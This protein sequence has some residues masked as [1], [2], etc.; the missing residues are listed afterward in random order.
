MMTIKSKIPNKVEL[1]FQRTIAD[2]EDKSTSITKDNDIEV[3][4]SLIDIASWNLVKI[5]PVFRV[6][7]K[8]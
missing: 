1:I 6:I 2:T 3:N 4:I 7:K 8:K 5:S